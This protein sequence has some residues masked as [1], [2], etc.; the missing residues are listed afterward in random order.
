MTAFLEKDKGKTGYISGSQW[1]SAVE[2][3][4]KLD[5]PWNMIRH[6]LVN[7]L[8]DGRVD[9]LSCFDQYVIETRLNKNGPSITETLYR[10]RSNLET[11]F[12]LMDKDNSGTPCII[13][14]SSLK[15]LFLCVSKL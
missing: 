6:Q 12:R 4:L 9:Y 7:V 15:M 10:N 8:P 13:L 2:S 5:V 11:I 1:S 14:L 3:V